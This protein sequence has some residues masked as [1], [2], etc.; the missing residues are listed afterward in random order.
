LPLTTVTAGANTFAGVSFWDLLNTT[1]GLAI[2][3][4]VKNDVL[5]MYVVAM[6]SDGY[7]SVFSLGEI[8]PLFGNEPDLVAFSIDGQ[9][10][11]T[12]GFAR[13]VAPDDIARGRFVS[14]LVSLEVYHAALAPLPEPETL[15]FMILGLVSLAALRRRRLARK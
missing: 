2:D 3:P 5:G 1:A 11:G 8:D 13:I 15:S 12:S 14:N 10:L 6:G 4:A 9:A 7:K